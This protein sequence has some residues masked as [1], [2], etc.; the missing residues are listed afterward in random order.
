MSAAEA[1]C[2]ALFGAGL[3]RVLP[4]LWLVSARVLPLAAVAPWLGWR[5]TAATVRVG[6]ALTLAL[7][8]APLALSAAPELPAGLLALALLTVREALVGVVFAIVTSIPLWALGWAGE[9]LD[10]WRGSPTD[11]SATEPALGTLHLAAGVVL[12][13]AVGGHR[14][15]IAALGQ[16][17]V[18]EP[19][20]SGAAATLGPF[21]LG[22]AE[23]VTG[24]LGLAMAFAAPA[25][26]AFVLL[27][28]ALAIAG[29][30]GPELRPWVVG[31]P[32][33]AALGVGLALLG[34]AA[35][36]PRL[37]SHVAGSIDAALELVRRLAG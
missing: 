10:R 23:L 30:V 29:R 18:D 13:V 14:L 12:F 25:A 20:G 28:L 19:V 17:F 5:G 22:A 9:L 16:S 21:A 11:A 7:A 37:P 27:E 32:L 36:L 15:A 35:V 3:E 33:R 8:L 31:M 24:A 26:I 1:A 4:V 34:L 6:V 2:R